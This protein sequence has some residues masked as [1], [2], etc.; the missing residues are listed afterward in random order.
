M[1]PRGPVGTNSTSLHNS[2][3]TTYI[4]SL[5]P[6]SYLY[7][8]YLYLLPQQEGFA[9]QLSILWVAHHWVFSSVLHFKHV[10]LIW[11]KLS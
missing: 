9:F 6:I 2:L 11:L 7:Y 3:S 10:Y 1:K 5:L 4:L 8:L